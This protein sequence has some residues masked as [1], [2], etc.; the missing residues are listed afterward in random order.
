MFNPTAPAP[1]SSARVRREWW[2]LGPVMWVFI[3]T[4]LGLPFAVFKT[5]DM[6]SE[7]EAVQ[8]AKSIQSV[9]SIMRSYYAKN[10]VRKVQ[11]G[12][13]EVV[14]TE[15]YHN[16]RGAIPIPATLSIE[17]GE[18]I[19]RQND[20]EHYSFQFVSDM[21]FHKRI[22]A[23]L[24]EFEIDALRA[25]RRIG[26]EAEALHR[27]GYWRLE[28]NDDGRS[29]VRLAMPVKMEATCVGC[30]NVHPDSPYRA[31]KVGDVR[32][33]Q[34]VSIEVDFHEQLSM[35][36]WLAGY[37]GFL[38]LTGLLALNEHKASMA[39]LKKL[40]QEMDRS[41]F[42]LHEKSEVLQRSVRELR[43]KTTVLDRAPFGILVFKPDG[44]EPT[45][46]YVNE[47]FARSTG[48]GQ[49][50]VMGRHPRFLFGPETDV[51][52]IASLNQAL[53]DHALKDVELRIYCHDGSQRLMRWLVFPCFSSEGA[54]LNMVACL[55]DVTEMRESEVERSRLIGELQESTKLEFLGLTIAG[56]AHDLNTPIGI[57]VTASSH[58]Q[59]TAQKLN[60]ELNQ[61]TANSEVL[62]TLSVKI[63]RSADMVTKNLA[64][65]AELVRGFKRT[66]ADVTR[67][68]WRKINL[69]DLVNSL[70]VT[71]S[72][73]MKRAKCQVE[74]VCS[75]K[76]TIYTEPGALSQAIT[77]LMVNAT[78]HAFEGRDDRRLR[79]EVQDTSD[80]VE[81]VVADNG[82]GM[83][84]EAAVKAFTPF[85][86]TKRGAGGSGLGLFSSR[87]A[88][89]T[90]LGG[91][92]TMTT[93][94][95]QGTI[96]LIR[97]QKTHQASEREPA[98][99]TDWGTLS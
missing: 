48:Y 95:G 49:E 40:N 43:T 34:E 9:V 41:R 51:E 20:N 33:I 79:V 76:V 26:S 38:G 97:L 98:V 60:D 67:N 74:V 19:R 66:S 6:H 47:A 56:M 78:L 80:A 18:E 83:S 72:P 2:G 4:L 88:V 99:N 96:F 44:A 10:V 68:E 25:F 70:V 29:L 39:E 28:S 85:F 93:R 32:G 82:V 57:A 11:D 65:A 69:G 52:A 37:L 12:T 91:S 73:V 1:T 87:R 84:E 64:K 58:V 24:D 94:P 13:G 45:L 62:Q 17:L 81:V 53:Q 55:S 90:V 23:P 7:V 75:Q 35:S 15:N 21:P 36:L 92:L 22:R 30:H 63:Q 61:P 77:N 14:V 42:E 5:L 54:L 71:M 50:Q 16:I 27:E 89:E 59:Q 3:F 86:T 46:E 31:W 8:Q